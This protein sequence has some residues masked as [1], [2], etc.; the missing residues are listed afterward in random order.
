MARF[1]EQNLNSFSLNIFLLFESVSDAICQEEKKN[2]QRI[3]DGIQY[4]ACIVQPA[5]ILPDKC[6]INAREIIILL[7]RML[8]WRNNRGICAR[9]SFC[10]GTAM[11]RDLTRIRKGLVGF[12]VPGNR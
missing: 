7:C 8:D 2:T 4:N 12:Q 3:I 1:F 5:A 6:R 11:K 10:R 9:V